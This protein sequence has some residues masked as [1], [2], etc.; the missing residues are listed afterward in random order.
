MDRLN[1]FDAADLPSL[2]RDYPIG[3]AFT[4]RSPA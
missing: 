4:R 2:R 1:Y 3:D